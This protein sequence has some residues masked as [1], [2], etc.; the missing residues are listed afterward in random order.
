M[1]GDHLAAVVDVEDVDVVAGETRGAALQVATQADEVAGEVDDARVGLRLLPR[2]GL[3]VAESARLQELLALQQHREA[4]SRHQHA[5]AERRALAAPPRKRIARIDRLRDPAAGR[6]FIVALD[7]DDPLRGVAR[8]R[9]AAD[10]R[11]DRPHVAA[12]VVGRDEI[13]PHWMHERRIPLAVEAGAAG[14]GRAGDPRVAVHVLGDRDLPRLRGVDHVVHLA[15]QVPALREVSEVGA[16]DELGGVE[17]EP[18]HAEL[19]EPHADVVLDEV[20]DLAATVVGAGVAPRGDR[21]IVVVEEDSAPRSLAPAVEAPEVHVGRAPVVVDD[22]AEDRD[23]PRV[24]RVDEALERVGTAVG[25][26]DRVEARRVVAPADLAGE[27]VDGHERDRVDA[28]VRQVIEAI[29]ALVERRRRRLA[30]VEAE[31]AGMDLH[32][33]EIVPERHREGR[34]APL[35]GVGVVDDVVVGRAG[36]DPAARIGLPQRL[37]VPDDHE[38]VL[39]ARPERR[40]VAAPEAVAFGRERGRG[41]APAV[42]GSGD[43]DRDGEGRPR[44]E[45]HALRGALRERDRADAGSVRGTLGDARGSRGEQQGDGEG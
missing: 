19:L 45:G 44:A 14:P 31:G 30:R 40:H 28:E 18:V 5:D 35:E 42:E 23:A 16:A 8:V 36:E 25:L 7:V 22:V 13:E 4:G 1:E 38:L 32:H 33:H 10:H 39:G 37:P 11:G 27:L 9:S 26:F 2:E 21:A 20:A 24:G 12:R 6:G 34:V 15:K 29:D 3:G 43:A 41:L 17:A